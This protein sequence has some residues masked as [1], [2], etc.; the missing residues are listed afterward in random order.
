MK[1]NKKLAQSALKAHHEILSKRSNKEKRSRHRLKLKKWWNKELNWIHVRLNN[2]YLEYR[3]SGWRQNERDTYR[4]IKKE[5]RARKRFN[6]KLKRDHTLR[7][8]EDLFNNSKENFWRKIARM[9]RKHITINLDVEKIKNEYEKIFTLSNLSND[10]E[11]IN[12]SK[13]EKFVHDNAGKTFKS[14]TNSS[15]IRLMLNGLSMNKAI[16]IRGISHEMLKY[17]TSNRLPVVLSKFFDLLTNHQITP[18]LFNISI[19]KPIIKDV[20][21]PNDDINNIRLVAISDAFANLYE[22]LLLHRI[23]SK[24][25]DHEKQFGFKANSSCNHAAYVLKVAVNLAK[26]RGQRLYACALDAIKAFDKVSRD[27][28]WLKMNDSG[29]DPEITLAVLRYYKLSVMLVQLEDQFSSSFIS[30][31]GVRQ[32]GVASP[33][34]FSIYIEELANRIENTMLGI[35]V[36]H[37]IINIMMYADDIILV[38]TNKDELQ[39]QLNVVGHLGIEYGIK[40]NQAKCELLVFNKN[41]KRS[42]HEANLDMNTKPVTLNGIEIPEVRSFRY[43]GMIFTEDCKSTDHLTKRRKAAFAMLSRIE[44]LGFNNGCMKPRIIGNMLKTYIRT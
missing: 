21:K 11:R 39:K 22:R 18:K 42:T 10:E 1:L 9:E 8:I 20:N 44:K 16:G 12:A 19:I 32:G 36:Y 5:F 15:L 29:V 23:K 24:H 27:K 34:L 25:R 14:S 13:V 31:L 40:F 6:Q 41:L 3:N 28:L 37:T 38:A 33:K 2:A 26:C 4:T 17:N 43:L 35:P 7:M 30:K